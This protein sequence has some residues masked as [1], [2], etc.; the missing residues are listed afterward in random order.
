MA[1][2]I[3]LRAVLDLIDS[4][5]KE[6]RELGKKAMEAHNAAAIESDGNERRMLLETRET[7]LRLAT[8]YANLAQVF[9]TVSTA[10]K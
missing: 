7:S 8:L 6:A 2:E 9:A 3:D 4:H 5:A 1:K 10:A